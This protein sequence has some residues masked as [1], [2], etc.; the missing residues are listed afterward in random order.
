MGSARTALPAID[1][2]AI[3]RVVRRIVEAY[4][5][6]RVVLFGSHARGDA[7]PDSDIDLFVEME[8]DLSPRDR[9]LALRRL[10]DDEGYP[11]DV[12]VLTPPEVTDARRRF[13]SILSYVDT[14]GRVMYERA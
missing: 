7:G 6:I 9:R 11:I 10:L 14:E 12:V 8:S 4:Q 2:A 3:D 13:G 5:P 1:Q